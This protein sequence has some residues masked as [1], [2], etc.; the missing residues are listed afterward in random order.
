MKKA[1]MILLA[2]VLAAGVMAAAWFFVSPLFIDEV[3]DEGFDYVLDNGQVDMESVMAMPQEQRSSMKSEIMSAAAAAPDRQASESMATEA[4]RVVARGEFVDADL[5]HKGS[6]HAT[7]YELPDGEHLV[8]LE[9][10]RTTNGPALVVYLARHPSP[11]SADDVSTRGFV[12]LGPLKGNVGNQNYPVPADIDITE[13][14]SVVIWCELFDV[15]FS[16]AA[17][18]R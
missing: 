3:V 12:S 1:L 7:L 14:N 2:L 10:F 8:R 5:I 18:D 4:P 11:M 15:L 6:G 13:F 16:P 9:D 17:L